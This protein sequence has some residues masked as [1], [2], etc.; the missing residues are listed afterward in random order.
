MSMIKKIIL[1]LVIILVLFLFLHWITWRSFSV[2]PPPQDPYKNRFNKKCVLVSRS[3]YRP[4]WFN[5][6]YISDE[7]CLIKPN[8]LIF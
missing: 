5:L 6:V 8:G 2:G 4:S 1:I 7:S 3:G